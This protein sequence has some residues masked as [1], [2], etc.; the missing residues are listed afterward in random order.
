MAAH[1]LLLLSIWWQH[2]VLMDK[3]AL[4]YT[5][6]AEQ[7][8]QGDFSGLVHYRLYSAFVLF[9]VPFL[10]LGSPG[11]AVA[12][13]VALG[14]AAAFAL[15]RI[16][17]ALNGS[18]WQADIVFA[19]FLLLYPIQTWT[20]AL[21]SESFFVSVS[22][23]F[24]SEAL[25]PKIIWW[26]FGALAIVVLFAR[27]VGVFF[28][29][30][31]LAWAVSAQLGL[32]SGPLIW[33][34]GFGVL[35]CVLFLPVLDPVLLGV[36]VEGHAIGGFPKYPGAG[37]SFNGTS[38]ASAELQLI[39]DHG[40]G[41]WCVLVFKRIGWLL[42]AGRPYFS[43][44]H[45]ALMAPVA[46]IYPF[47]MAALYRQWRN[48]AIQAMATMLLLNIAIVAFTFAEWNGRFLVPMLP[49]LIVL[50]ALGLPARLR[51]IEAPH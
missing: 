38:L 48:P 35:L 16:V 5:G 11:A 4:K 9:L 47:A 6:S 44:L 33:A 49:V 24:L 32:K 39:A 43:V 20:L 51:N 21:Y 14:L 10:A 2:G 17:L 15:R 41:A 42:F 7:I 23:L 36:V 46:L 3:E 40:L 34:V 45:N 26:R 13:Q 29:A 22:V 30:P 1:A 25:R 28:V 31:L 27:P 19:A 12:A 8:L 37:E 50:A 18:T